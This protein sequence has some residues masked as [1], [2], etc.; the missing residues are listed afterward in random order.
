[1]FSRPTL[2]QLRDQAVSDILIGTGLPSLLRRS[3]LRALAYA[4]AGLVQGLYGYLDW[5]SRQSVPFTATGAFLEAWAALVGITRLPAAAANGMATLTGSGPIPAGS[6]LRRSDGAEYT[7]LAAIT[8][9]T[10]GT[11]SIIASVAG[12]DG[13]LATG[14]MLTLISPVLGLSSAAIVASG[15]AGADQELDQALRTRML[16]RYA[17]PPQGGDAA[18]Y[19]GWALAVPGVTRAWT[20][21][22]SMGAG[23]VVVY[24]MWDNSEAASLGFP[25]GTNGVASAE[26]R[27]VVAT[28][29]QLAVANALYPLRP[30]TALVYSVAPVPH[31]VNFV[32]HPKAVISAGGALD[33]AIKAAIDG[34]FLALADPLATELETDQFQVA[35]AAVAGM[36]DF[37][38]TSPAAPITAANGSLPVRGTLAYA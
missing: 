12:A 38:M 13:T 25:Q 27:D 2:T 4:I 37:T 11:V 26:T 24:T 16:Q 1:M 20:K 8:I 7:T 21:P 22:L 5:I 17:A 14:S 3:P 35:I 36:P 34:V 6:V 31:L 32:I 28:G 18:D 29:D 19:I 23:T 33:L 15:S 30:A 9:V 10:T